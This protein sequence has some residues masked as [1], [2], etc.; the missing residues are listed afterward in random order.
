MAGEVKAVKELVARWPRA[1]FFGEITK[2]YRVSEG[3]LAKHPHFVCVEWYRDGT[4]ELIGHEAFGKITHLREFMRNK[5]YEEN[6][7]IYGEP[8]D[9]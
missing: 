8:E 2:L 1:G 4:T 3:K 5:T 7:H 9:E 6:P